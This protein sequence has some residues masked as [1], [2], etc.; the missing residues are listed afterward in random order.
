[1]PKITAS[2]FQNM[3][4]V[5]VD[6]ARQKFIEKHFE[7]MKQKLR[8]MAKR[9]KQQARKFL[10]KPSSPLPN[11]TK[12]PRMDSKKLRNSVYYHIRSYKG[13]HSFSFKIAYG[14]HEVYSNKSKKWPDFRY[15]EYLN[16]WKGKTFA[17]YRER[18]NN[19]LKKR[20][21]HFINKRKNLKSYQ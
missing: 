14:F 7:S 1:M 19:R 3:I 20:I 10:S 16:E 6:K 8:D 17:G 21:E 15:G 12:Y 2:Y 11:R 18:I 13:K 9:W 5:K 4:K